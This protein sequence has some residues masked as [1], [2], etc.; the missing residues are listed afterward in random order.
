[1][2]N[3]IVEGLGSIL[4]GEDLVAHRVNLNALLAPRK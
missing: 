1:L 2:A 4:S 3:Q